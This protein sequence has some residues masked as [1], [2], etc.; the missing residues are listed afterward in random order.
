MSITP[1]GTPRP[2]PRATLLSEGLA[3]LGAVRWAFVE[4][5][6]RAV[7]EEGLLVEVI[8]FG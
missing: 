6:E 2:A 8:D 5:E 4:A 7:S 1:N 3:V